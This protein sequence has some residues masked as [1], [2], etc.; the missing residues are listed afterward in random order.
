MTSRMWRSLKS[1]TCRGW[2]MQKICDALY[3]S[4]QPMQLAV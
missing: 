4:V 1:N 3:M 2:E